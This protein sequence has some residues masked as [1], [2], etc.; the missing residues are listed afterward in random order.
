MY[1]K[2]IENLLVMTHIATG[3]PES[4]ILTQDEMV[5]AKDKSET[6]NESWYKLCESVKERTGLEIEGNFELESLGGR[7]IH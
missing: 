3:Y 6:I 4:V 2:P 1:D 5:L 7:P